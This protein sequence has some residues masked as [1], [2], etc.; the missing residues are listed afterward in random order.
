M[1]DDHNQFIVTTRKEGGEHSD[2]TRTYPTLKQAMHWAWHAHTDPTFKSVEL[3]SRKAT[4]SSWKVH[5]IHEP[6]H[7]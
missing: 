4:F 2:Q 7:Y 6:D 5:T 1:S 3:K